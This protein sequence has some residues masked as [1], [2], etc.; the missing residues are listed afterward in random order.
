MI[1]QQG[2]REQT[3]GRVAA[4]GM[5]RARGHLNVRPIW[6]FSNWWMVSPESRYHKRFQ[7]V[8]GGGVNWRGI[9]WGLPPPSSCTGTQVAAQRHSGPLC[10]RAK[11]APDEETTRRPTRAWARG[12]LPG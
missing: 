5:T 3:A 8:G 11:N 1:V 7:R 2:R 12:T 4:G 9:C 10:R 6:I